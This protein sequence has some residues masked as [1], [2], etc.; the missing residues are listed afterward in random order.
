[1]TIEKAIDVIK[2]GSKLENRVDRIIERDSA[3]QVAF[4]CMVALDK[5]DEELQIMM[6]G[7]RRTFSN[8]ETDDAPFYDG[9]AT[10]LAI[11]KKYTVEA[12][13]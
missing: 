11:V 7:D 2:N 1:M 4:K 5:I 8:R 6:E 9:I 12:E 10:A 13:G 3:D